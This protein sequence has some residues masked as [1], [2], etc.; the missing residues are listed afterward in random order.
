MSLRSAFGRNIMSYSLFYC[1]RFSSLAKAKPLLFSHPQSTFL[2]FYCYL[3]R[4][5]KSPSQFVLILIDL[6]KSACF[7]QKGVITFLLTVLLLADVMPMI[8]IHMSYADC[9]ALHVCFSNTISY[10]SYRVAFKERML[11]GICKPLSFF[12]FENDSF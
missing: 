4:L 11:F 6:S 12:I 9:N 1:R 3:F 2:L 5:L 7:L 10:M 8:A